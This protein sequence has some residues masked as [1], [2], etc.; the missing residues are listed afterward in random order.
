MI[1]NGNLSFD[2]FVKIMLPVISGEFQENKIESAFKQFDL[3]DLAHFKLFNFFRL[4]LNFLLNKS[5]L[6]LFQMILDF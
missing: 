3:S 6:N 1:E 4:L 2:E 5:K